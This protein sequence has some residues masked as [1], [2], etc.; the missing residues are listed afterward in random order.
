MYTCIQRSS[1]STTVN[2]Q[3]RAELRTDMEVLLLLFLLLL[4]VSTLFYSFKSKPT[5]TPFPPGRTGWPFIGETIEYHSMAKRGCIEKFITDRMKKYSNSKLFRT[6]YLGENMVF[7]CSA[8]GNK[9]LFS[10]DQNKLV[11]PWLPRLFEKLLLGSG[12]QT[13]LSEEFMAM[14]KLTGAFTEPMTLK[15]YVEIIDAAT[16]QHLHKYWDCSKEEVK[17]HSLAKQFTFSLACQLML[18]IQDEETAS[19]LEKLADCIRTELIFILPLNIPGT[20]C[21]R[22]VKAVKELRQKLEAIIKQRKTDQK[23]ELSESKDILSQLLQEKNE[24]KDLS[25]FQ[26][27]NKVMALFIAAYDN[28][29]ITMVTII[30]CLAELPH[31]YEQVLRGMLIH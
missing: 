18:N 17:V 19:E 5:S 14:R 25:E 15:N 24:G 31:V 6:S 28:P 8:E 10:N 2:K 12:N 30:K 4:L 16:K 7:L 3:T 26:I 21:H 20:K 13:T 22:I 23:R 9:L 29:S 1:P 27:V 11:K